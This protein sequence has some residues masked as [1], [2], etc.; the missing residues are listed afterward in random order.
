MKHHFFVSVAKVYTVKDDTALLPFIRNCAVSLMRMLPRPF[1]CAV[2]DLRNIAVF[3]YFGI[4]KFNITV[5]NE[6]IM[7]RVRP[8]KPFVASTAPSNAHKT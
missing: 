5:Q 4:D 7:P 2:I 6:T 1:A 3:V 8:P